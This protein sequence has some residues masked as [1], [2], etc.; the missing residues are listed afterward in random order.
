M[1]KYSKHKMQYKPGDFKVRSDESGFTVMNSETQ[2]T[3][4][5]YK[6]HKSEWDP[7]QPQLIIY[8]HDD[9]I[10]VHNSRPTSEDDADLPFGEGN[11][12]DL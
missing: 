9:R 5:G 3:W 12:N 7:K 6:R 11:A 4:E 2:L 1:P 10:A 8:P